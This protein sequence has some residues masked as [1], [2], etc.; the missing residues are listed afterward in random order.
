MNERITVLIVDDYAHVRHGLA[1]LM[2]TT[3]DIVV[4]GEA[5]D[6]PT[7]V[8]QALALYPDVIVMDLIEPGQ[9]G[10]ETIE[11]IKRMVPQVRILV[12]SN[13]S[14]EQRVFS[15]F[16]AGAQGYL[17]KDAMMTNVV[18]AIRDIYAGKLT[19]HPSLTDIFMQAL[20]VPA[21]SDQ[22]NLYSLPQAANN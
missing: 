10:L 18:E 7:A 15:A 8:Q 17:L 2:A 9:Q 20:K 21:K 13:I 5:V 6:G 16:Q 19:L 1:A 3:P 11:A 14:E 22:E 12:L 4:V